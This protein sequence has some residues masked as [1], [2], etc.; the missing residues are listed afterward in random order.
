MNALL[1]HRWLSRVSDI[2]NYD[3]C[4]RTNR[5]VY[6]L[7][8]P[9]WTLL[10]AVIGSAL[11]GAMINPQIFALTGILLGV[12]L[13][14]VVWPWIVVRGLE[15][16]VR[17]AAS[18]TSENQPVSVQI[19]ITNRWPWPVWGL[20]LEQGFAVFADVTRQEIGES[21]ALARVPGWSTSEFAWSF[22]P[23][24][25]G[26]Y[27]LETPAVETGFP[28]GMV[29]ARKECI[30]D[31]ELL[32]WPRT[33][34]LES[35]PDTF[36]Q[37]PREDQLTDRKAGD[38][39]DMLGTRPFRQ[40]DSLRRVHWAQTARQGRMIVCE[41]QSPAACS[42]RVIVDLRPA[43]H[44]G[45]GPTSTLEQA[46]RITA[47][48]CQSLRAQ[49]ASVECVIGRE[50]VTLGNSESDWRRLL[51]LLARVPALGLDHAPRV[52]RGGRSVSQILITTDAAWDG[53][54]AIHSAESRSIVVSDE[55][56]APF[57]SSRPWIQIASSTTALESLRDL[58]G[59]ACHAA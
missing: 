56:R 31:N 26:V 54:H 11:C 4:P 2:L 29:K 39:G 10:L 1:R 8:N 34:T 59:R 44:S 52:A 18:R 5:F 14:G 6:W 46:L 21:V 16:R 15:C 37:A 20:A 42:V 24:R 32:V 13:L 38:C 33:V 51:D 22:I 28:F 47:S 27:P 49:R 17:F 45:E 9:M 12:F 3:F 48:V 36:D 41:R 23:Q 30:A 55:D 58:W 57:H 35:L 50:V 40:G 25:R 43:I 53:A 19:R 7:K